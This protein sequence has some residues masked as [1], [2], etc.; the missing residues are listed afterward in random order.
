MTP[1]RAIPCGALIVI[2]LIVIVFW[3]VFHQNG[4][5][6]TYSADKNTD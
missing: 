3:M 2:Y 4:S 5:T 6:L 1:N